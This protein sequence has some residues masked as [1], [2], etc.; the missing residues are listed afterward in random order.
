MS[1]DLI[2]KRLRNLLKDHLAS[3]STLREIENEFEAAEIPLAESEPRNM[4]GQRR[5]LVQGYYDGLDFK[6][7][8]DARKFLNVLAVFMGNL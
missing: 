2:S 5:T 6:D 1:K 3:N 8:G 7:P 4:A